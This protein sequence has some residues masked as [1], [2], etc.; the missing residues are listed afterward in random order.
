MQSERRTMKAEQRSRLRGRNICFA[1]ARGRKLVLSCTSSRSRSRLLGLGR[2]VRYA[3]ML[4]LSVE[5]GK[6]RLYNLVIACDFYEIETLNMRWGGNSQ[7]H[8][9]IFGGGGRSRK[10]AFITNLPTY[11]S[12]YVTYLFTS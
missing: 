9:G 2:R 3:G 7:T 8:N 11:H 12:Q 10:V 5:P 4:V 1:A 6:G